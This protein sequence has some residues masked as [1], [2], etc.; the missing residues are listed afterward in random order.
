MNSAISAAHFLL[1]FQTAKFDDS[2]PKPC[3]ELARIQPHEYG[4]KFGANVAAEQARFWPATCARARE[5]F[6]PRLW[7][8]NGPFR[9]NSCSRDRIDYALGLSEVA[10]LNHVDGKHRQLLRMFRQN[11]LGKANGRYVG[12]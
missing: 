9:M 6:W 7:L 8:R 11:L 1:Y 12:I 5:I 2:I 10:P 4:R 3:P